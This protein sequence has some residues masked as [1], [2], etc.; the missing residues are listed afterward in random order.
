MTTWLANVRSQVRCGLGPQW[1][2]ARINY[3][4]VEI[5]GDWYSNL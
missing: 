5:E 4:G 2:Q 3:V 1:S